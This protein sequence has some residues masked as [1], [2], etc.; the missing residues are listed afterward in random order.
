MTTTMN[1]TTTV[2]AEDEAPSR[3]VDPELVALAER[4]ATLAAAVAT[5][6]ADIT[7]AGARRRATK[8]ATQL[9][10]AGRLIARGAHLP[11][12]KSRLRLERL[13]ARPATAVLGVAD[14][15]ETIDSE[16]ASMRSVIVGLHRWR[17]HVASLP[18]DTEG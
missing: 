12:P 1:P 18:A 11:S 4:F 16:I 2:T 10:A 8:L 13:A 7:S 6:A 15:A 9:A 3:H 5:T 14:P 17:G